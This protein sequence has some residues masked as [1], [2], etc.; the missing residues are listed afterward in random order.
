MDEIVL[1]P[2]GV[3]VQWFASGTGMVK[4]SMK[5]MNRELGVPSI[6]KVPPKEVLRLRV[7]RPCSVRPSSGG[8]RNDARVGEHPCRSPGLMLIDV[9]QTSNS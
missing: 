2:T 5:Q 7:L 3:H 9:L 8:L 6:Y 4:N 1:L